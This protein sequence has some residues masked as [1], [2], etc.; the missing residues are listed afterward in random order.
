MMWVLLLSPSY[1]FK[2]CENLT[3]E[4]N[5]NNTF[6]KY[7][8]LPQWFNAMNLKDYNTKLQKIYGKT[9]KIRQINAI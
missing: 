4:D 2:F 5:I 7:K 1:H 6:R 9:S 3:F 8:V